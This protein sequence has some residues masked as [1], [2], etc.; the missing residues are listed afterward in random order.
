MIG[1][2]ERLDPPASKNRTP[3]AWAAP[4]PPSFV[5]LPPMPRMTRSWHQQSSACDSEL[6]G[7]ECGG[8]HRIT[9]V[10]SH[11]D[12]QPRSR[13]HLD[14][15]GRG[16]STEPLPSCASIGL[17]ERIHVPCSCPNR[18][19]RSRLRASASCPRHRPR[20]DRD[21][22]QPPGA[23]AGR[24]APSPVRRPTLSERS[25]ETVG[26]THDPH[27][28]SIRRSV[29]RRIEPRGLGVVAGL[30]RQR[31]GIRAVT[32]YPS[33]ANRPPRILDRHFRS[34]RHQIPARAARGCET[35]RVA[36]ARRRTT[37]AFV[38]RSSTTRRR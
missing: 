5:A 10:K 14:D 24:L 26:R 37:A 3:S 36:G 31:E 18:P 7:A 30:L 9:F 17:P 16:I 22:C 11:Q 4:Q 6:T 35:C 2:V 25:L 23:R 28:A 12:R 34:A 19:V 20:S 1:V 21:R 33:R 15:H 27:A 8:Q 29:S 13:R 38:N 32:R